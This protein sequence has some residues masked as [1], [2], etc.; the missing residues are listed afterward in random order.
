MSKRKK[1]SK[2]LK[3]KVVREYE[4]GEISL[5]KLSKKY[6]AEYTCVRKW[7]SNYREF[8]IDSILKEHANLNYSAKFKREAV[9]SYLAGGK[10]LKE[11]AAIYKILAPGSLGKWV[12]QYNN[13][14]ELTDSRLEGVVAMVKGNKR[15]TTLEERIDI[16]A[17][18]LQHKRNYADAAKEYQVSYQQVYTW[19]YRYEKDGPD[20]LQDR[21][22]KKK[23]VEKM[24]ELERLKIENRMLKA[25]M[26]EKQ[27]ELDFLKKVEEIERR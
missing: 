1:Y 20:G 19:V 16:V 13:H 6:D 17:Y 25:K 3:V 26:K 8:G 11:V 4:A 15:K 2:E 7:W 12:K 5:Y 22:G 23:P 18:C 27:M 10:T 24:T 9:L 21:R 14:E